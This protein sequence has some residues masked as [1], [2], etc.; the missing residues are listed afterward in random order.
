MKRIAA[1]LPLLA[2]AACQDVVS[3]P[4]AAEPSIPLPSVSVSGGGYIVVLKEGANPRSVAALLGINPRFVYTDAINGFA[5][6]PCQTEASIGEM[7][8]FISELI[9][10]LKKAQATQGNWLELAKFLAFG[11]VRTLSTVQRQVSA[12]GD[13]LP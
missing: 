12:Y 7:A 11:F 8:G 2:L 3:P 9:E 1:L 5:A 6:M 13:P 4:P 10:R